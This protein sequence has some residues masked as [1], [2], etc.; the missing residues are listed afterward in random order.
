[1]KRTGMWAMV[2]VI[3]ALA[4]VCWLDASRGKA[5]D[6]RSVFIQPHENTT[7]LGAAKITGK[8]GSKWTIGVLDALTDRERKDLGPK[9]RRW[10]THGTS[11]RIPAPR[12][13]LAVLATAGGSRQALLVATHLYSWD[14]EFVEDAVVNINERA[15]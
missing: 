1:M 3:A 14:G 2:L 15:P 11:M 5:V 4:G 8:L 6:G 10:L 9:A 7:I 13:A 12:Q